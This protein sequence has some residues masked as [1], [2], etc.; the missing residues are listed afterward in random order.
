MRA[1]QPVLARTPAQPSQAAVAAA[2]TPSPAHQTRCRSAF[3]PLNETANPSVIEASVAR[4]SRRPRR[5][6]RV[7]APLMKNVAP[8]GRAP[9]P[10]RRE[11]RGARSTPSALYRGVLQGQRVPRRPSPKTQEAHALAGLVQ[12]LDADGERC[13]ELLPRVL[14]LAFMMVDA[15]RRRGRC[16]Q[17][18]VLVL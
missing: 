5:S 10:G 13:D 18:R 9:A 14:D 7:D 17:L 11:R 8:C 1:A 6:N 16:R 12:P 4:A 15:R 2:M 3:R